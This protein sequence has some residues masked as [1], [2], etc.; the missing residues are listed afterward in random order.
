[1][2]V[3]PVEK[4]AGNAGHGVLVFTTT[5]SGSSTVTVSMFESV[6]IPRRAGSF[7][8]APRRESMLS[9]TASASTG[10][11]S[12]NFTPGRRRDRP[13]VEGRV[14]ADRLREGWDVLALAV[15]NHERVGRSPMSPACPGPAELRL[16]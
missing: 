14:G 2:P 7:G 6:K 3:R 10:S 12:W 11:P 1:M 16:W 4:Y 5:V 13:L 15:E 8:F 9:F